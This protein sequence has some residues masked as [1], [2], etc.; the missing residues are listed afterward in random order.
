MLAAASVAAA[1]V[2]PNPV[3]AVGE[4]GFNCKQ[5]HGKPAQVNPNPG[6]RPPVAIGDSTML[7][8]IPNLTA[9]GYSVNARGC[10]GFREAVNIAARIKAKHK[11]GHLV[12]T[13]AYGNGGVNPTLI[14]DMLSVLGPHRVLVLVTAYNADTG[15]PPAPDT[16]ELFRAERQYPHRI[17][18]IDWV[19]YS[20]SHHK[21]DPKPG[22]WFLPDLFHPN[23]AGA[24][25]YAQFLATALPLAVNGTFPP[26]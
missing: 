4:P 19:A 1:L 5:I 13:N 7:L 16:D 9:V 24:D 22:A 15:K 23:F 6:G 2:S 8:P 11:L 17:A 18:V 26:I 21:A 25:A 12:L 3:G 20:R 14:A 10:R